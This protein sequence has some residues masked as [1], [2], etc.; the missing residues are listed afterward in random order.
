MISFDQ[1]GQTE[2]PNPILY[3][4]GKESP[5]CGDLIKSTI[6]VQKYIP[7]IPV[8]TIVPKKTPVKIPLKTPEI[9]KNLLVE[10]SWLEGV[11]PAFMLL[12]AVIVFFMLYRKNI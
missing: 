8:K 1:E 11:I 6:L 2:L 4:N 5:V 10:Y 12:L 7:P 9:P 3:V